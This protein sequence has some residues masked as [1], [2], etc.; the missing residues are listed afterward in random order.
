MAVRLNVLMIQPPIGDRSAQQLCEQLVGELIGL[1]GIDLSLIDRLDQIQPSSTDQLTLE[2]LRE[3]VAVLGWG[4]VE[5]T[6][7]ALAGLGFTGNR[8]RHA[9]DPE[10]AQALGARRVYVYDLR[11]MNAGEV[12]AALTRLLVSRQVRTFDLGG[13]SISRSTPDA[14]GP[15]ADREN[16]AVET[17]RDS[18][19]SEAAPESLDLDRLV[20]QLDQLDP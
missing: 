18:E 15:E 9:H 10:A 8:T 7:A 14:A 11:Q 3:D 16:S 4:A 19:Q 12:G 1:A 20:D 17:P 13:I 5:Q 2:G 6:S